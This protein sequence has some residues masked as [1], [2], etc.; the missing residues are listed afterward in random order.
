[1]S[2]EEVILK[3]QI[4]FNNNWPAEKEVNTEALNLLLKRMDENELNQLIASVFVKENESLATFTKDKELAKIFSAYLDV[5]HFLPLHPDLAFDNIWRTLESRIRNYLIS[6]K[7]FVLYLS[8]MVLA[9]W[10]FSLRM[11][12]T[13]SQRLIHV[14]VVLISMPMV[15]VSTSSSSSLTTFMVLRTSLPLA[16]TTRTLS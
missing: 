5:F 4:Y 1:M 8:L 3:R 6:L 14:L 12:N 9:I 13:T 2:I 10:I 16:S 11:V 7:R 15:Q